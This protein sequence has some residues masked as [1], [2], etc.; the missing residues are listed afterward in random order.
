MLF[1]DGRAYAHWGPR[2]MP[3]ADALL[4]AT[5]ALLLLGHFVVSR[6]RKAAKENFG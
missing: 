6:R 1:F 4:S 2:G 5:G 3:A